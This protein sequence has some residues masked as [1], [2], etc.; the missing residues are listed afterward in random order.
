MPISNAMR[1]ALRA[2]SYPEP[3]IRKTYPLE[4][5]VK[6]LASKMGTLQP[7]G[8]YSIDSAFCHSHH[9]IPLRIPPTARK[10]WYTKIR[11]CCFSMAAAG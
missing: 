7:N 6:L 10:R 8:C 9:T 5:R 11:C 1:A 4:R 3:D 2:L